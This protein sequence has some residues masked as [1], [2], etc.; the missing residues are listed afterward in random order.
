MSRSAMRSLARLPCVPADADEMELA[1]IAQV[2][3]GRSYWN[4]MSG[5]SAYPTGASSCLTTGRAQGIGQALQR[6]LV[7]KAG[8]PSTAAASRSASRSSARPASSAP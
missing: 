4:A 3:M 2:T 7:L 8:G 6:V 1:V 5:F